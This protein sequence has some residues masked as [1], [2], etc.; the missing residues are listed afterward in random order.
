MCDPD[1]YQQFFPMELPGDVTGRLVDR[2]TARKAIETIGAQ[3]FAPREALGYFVPPETRR[4]TLERAGRRHTPS[5][6]EWIVFY[7]SQDEPV[8]WLY[9]YMEDEETFF[10]DTVG[11]IPAFRHRGIYTAFLKQLIAYLGAVGYERLTTSHHPNNRAVM[12][13][14]L[15]AGFNIVGIELHESCGAI[16][17]TAYLFHDDRRESFRQV[18]SLAPDP[19]SHVG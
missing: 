3:I 11:L 7:S 14:E 18:C 9:G 15:K 5:S 10:I 2:D 19:A 12:I 4:G 8:G 1:I 6:P 13:A 16:V 17:K